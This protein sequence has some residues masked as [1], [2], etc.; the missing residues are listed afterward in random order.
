[1]LNHISAVEGFMAAQSST[2]EL[3]QHPK[4]FVG[5]SSSFV[6]ELLTLKKEILNKLDV[7]VDISQLF[8]RYL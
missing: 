3:L 4:E 1:M 8:S 5:A 2:E 7:G 6:P